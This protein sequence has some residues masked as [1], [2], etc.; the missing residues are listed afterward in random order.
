MSLLKRKRG[1][2]RQGL[3]EVARNLL[4]GW[5]PPKDVDPVRRQFQPTGNSS[6][7]I[8]QLKLAY[9][10]DDNPDLKKASLQVVSLA[11]HIPPGNDKLDETLLLSAQLLLQISN[12]VQSGKASVA[13]PVLSDYIGMME[14]VEAML[15]SRTVSWENVEAHLS[16]K[17]E[18][19]K[20]S[21]CSLLG[22]CP[23]KGNAQASTTWTALL[24]SASTTLS[25]LKDVAEIVPVDILKGVT[26]TAYSLLTAVEQ[27]R[28]NIDEMRQIA[29]IAAD[30]VVSLTVLCAEKPNQLSAQFER[31]FKAF[32]E[33][34]TDIGRQCINMS[35]KS[36]LSRFLQQG[37]H[38]GDLTLLRGELESAISKFQTETQMLLHFDVRIF[39][40]VVNA[41]LD[42]DAVNAL[43]EPDHR[44]DRLD[45]Y[46]AASRDDELEAILKWADDPE[47][48]VLWIH[49]AA[50]LGKSTLMHK[51]VAVLAQQGRLA[52]SAFF[53]RKKNRDAIPTIKAV[54]RELANIHPRAV[55]A[56]AKAAR[57]CNAAHDS[58]LKYLQVYIIEPVRS[59]GLPYPL[60]LPLDALDEWDHHETFLR[61]LKHVSSTSPFLKFLFT[62]RWLHSVERG[63]KHNIV[64]EMALPPVTEEVARRYFEARFSDVQ[65]ETRTLLFNSIPQLA[66]LAKGLLV[67]AATV[68]NLI[69]SDSYTRPPVHTLLERILQSGSG[70]DE[71]ERLA[72]LY[73]EALLSIL[74]PKS[75]DVEVG[76]QILSHMV[77]LQEAVDITTF[78]ELVDLP[79]Y[80]QAAR[81]IHKRLRILQI[82]ATFDPNVIEPMSTRFHASFLDF[83]TSSAVSPSQSDMTTVPLAVDTAKAHLRSAKKCLSTLLSSSPHNHLS[84]RPLPPALLY[85]TKYWPFHLSHGTDRFQPL[86]PE[87]ES[88]L[89]SVSDD[90]TAWWAKHFVALV[91]PVESGELAEW[92]GQ[93]A[94]KRRSDIL[95]KVARLVDQRQPR[96]EPAWWAWAASPWEVA[97]ILRESRG[98]IDLLIQ[99]GD[100]YTPG[101]M[102]PLKCAAFAVHILKHCIAE[103][104]SQDGRSLYSLASALYSSYLNTDSVLDIDEAIAF[105]RG[106]LSLR[107][108]PHPDRAVTLNNLAVHLGERFG[109]QGNLADI[110]DAIAFGREALSLR[111][112][113]H[114]DRAGT[115]NKIAIDL[116][117]RFK[118]QGNLADID[119][120]IA[121][122]REAL[123]LRP[124]PH[125]ERS[126]TLHGL[127]VYLCDRFRKQGNLADIDDAI[128]FGREA[129]SLRPHPH[130]ERSWTLHS[131]AVHLCD[132]FR[133]QGNLA[134]IDDA[135]AFGRE[136]LSLRPH[137][138]PE[139]S[140]TLHSLAVHLCDRFRKQGNLAD[141]DDAIA[142]GREALSLRPHPHPERSWTLHSLAVHLCDRFKKQGNLAD[143]DDAIA[144]GREVLSLRPHPHP[145]RSETLHNLAIHLC[146][147]FKKLGDL[148]DIDD[149]IAFGREALSLRPH[150]HPGRSDTLHDLVLYLMS[151]CRK[152]VSLPHLE[153]A[154]SLCNATLST[155]Q[156]SHR[157]YAVFSRWLA[158]ARELKDQHFNA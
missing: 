118:K 120:A 11:A 86:P 128:A 119:D 40:E 24:G 105:G 66:K 60:V 78:T 87:L 63:L 117:H 153:E 154:I 110:D 107:P 4:S 7:D 83:L 14:D 69:L 138:H 77:I 36:V 61:E 76:M 53:V 45:E 43:P 108:H 41:K 42:Q 133:K 91:C 109:K 102:V 97:V 156:P 111:P 28:S 31:C 67:W 157:H 64:K 148:A 92:E 150:P 142:F 52:S 56:V 123:S 158:E 93:L 89:G 146:D 8:A 155:I 131:L 51:V 141:I 5:K 98:S 22:Y 125:P 130:P 2:I 106:A 38:Q 84:S 10:I 79:Q 122:G 127:A 134:D 114:P 81:E 55:P 57:T 30:F 88:L 144:F 33:K 99:L 49:G 126:E 16:H 71:D 34:L 143:I 12:A 137:P 145:D 124:H 115:L 18:E 135:I 29:S 62:S 1:A 75:R 13:E 26:E 94:G 147:R 6:R 73:R 32:D 70:V 136:A 85:S 113:L 103:T 72:T 129:L 68:C 50:G 23:S 100:F 149:A 96:G 121:F 112:H 139:R 9:L 116:C 58:I 25:V 19:I 17:I 21:R 37:A 48:R 65:G 90:M 39:S 95:V 3:K 35:Q 151:R 20:R 47:L 140:A 104:A 46:L 59:L 54:A 101:E 44:G 82:R 80:P 27:T 152:Q 15:A 74:G 132:R